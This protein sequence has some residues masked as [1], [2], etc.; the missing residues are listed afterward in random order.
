M[1]NSS[2][3]PN[4]QA[5]K[6]QPLNLARKAEYA[7]QLGPKELAAFWIKLKGYDAHVHSEKEFHGD[8]VY[9]YYQS[10]LVPHDY[11]QE[12]FLHFAESM[13]VKGYPKYKRKF[14][15]GGWDL[16]I[17]AIGSEKWLAKLTVQ[18]ET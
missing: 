7:Y 4:L 9:H 5:Q 3:V 13:A 6:Q 11:A 1:T 18:S 12:E 15:L 10:D 2:N 16:A 14:L 17:N 8:K